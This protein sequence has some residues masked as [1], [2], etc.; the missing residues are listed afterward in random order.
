MSFDLARYREHKASGLIKVQKQ[1]G[2]TIIVAKQ[3]DR[4]TGAPL[5][6]IPVQI[7][8]EMLTQLMQQR[9]AAQ[10]LL[11]ES[12]A[13]LTDIYGDKKENDTNST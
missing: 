12:E 7:T 5:E 2:N 11:D 3:F 4:F 13:L 10:L 9:R 1:D 8:D 6:D